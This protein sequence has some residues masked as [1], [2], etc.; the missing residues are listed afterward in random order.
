MEIILT[1]NFFAFTSK[2]EILNQTLRLYIYVCFIK[3]SYSIV[4]ISILKNHK[5]LRIHLPM[6]SSWSKFASIESCIALWFFINRS[7]D[8]KGMIRTLYAIGLSPK[9]H[10]QTYYAV[11]VRSD[12]WRRGGNNSTNFRMIFETVWRYRLLLRPLLKMITFLKNMRLTST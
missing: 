11:R 2:N 3:H 4:Y 10:Q 12:R 8:F 9:R 7:W 6:N 1:A 5:S